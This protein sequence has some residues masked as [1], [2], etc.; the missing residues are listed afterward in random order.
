[1]LSAAL[2]NPAS[3][4]Q[5]I[6]P[7]QPLHFYKMMGGKHHLES[8]NLPADQGLLVTHTD[9]KI[10]EML[11]GTPPLPNKMLCTLAAVTVF[12]EHWKSSVK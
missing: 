6:L 8:E 5:G 10:S 1:M 2:C 12:L 11:G 9:G 3:I 7:L 4:S